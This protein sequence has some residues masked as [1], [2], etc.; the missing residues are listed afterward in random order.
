MKIFF[1]LPLLSLTVIVSLL[2]GQPCLVAQDRIITREGD[3]IQGYN[4][5]IGTS[6]VFYTKSSD[7]DTVIYKIA[8]SELLM[9]RKEGGEKISF[10]DGDNDSPQPTANQPD[11]AATAEN[12]N[13]FGINPNLKEDNLELVRQFNSGE[14]RYT[15]DDTDRKWQCIVCVLG[16]KEGSIIDTP[17]LSATFSMKR[18]YADKSKEGNIKRE[19]TVGLEESS[20]FP[21]KARIFKMVINLY[22]KTNKTIYIDLANSFVSTHGD[23]MAYYVP[24]ATTV[25]TGSSTGVVANLGA[26]TAAAGIGGTIGVL[27]SG[28]SV[29]GESGSQKSTT[30]FS[31]RI[32]AIPPMSSKSL[33]AMSI[34]EGQELL[35]NTLAAKYRLFN[36]IIDQYVPYFLEIGLL[37]EKKDKYT[38]PNLSRGE[39]IDIPVDLD[40]I[41][42]SAFLT[43]SL[44][45][46]LTTTSS[47]KMDFC[48][49]QIM[50]YDDHDMGFSGCLNKDV[51]YSECPLVFTKTPRELRGL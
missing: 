9:I 31:Q 18:Y 32:V 42:L 8:K 34:E 39:K 26:V 38:I 12:S 33:P 13:E 14:L 28:V 4:I 40:V 20:P 48:L 23:A 11:A 29:G 27:A 43:Y 1:I 51:D 37:K 44:D 49:R 3:V 7:A 36:K 15:N 6:A 17:E 47:M 45:E 16:L 24:S 30:T 22:N 5:E 41:P 19:D 10:T 46:N 35:E 50:G 21:F 25:T 2:L